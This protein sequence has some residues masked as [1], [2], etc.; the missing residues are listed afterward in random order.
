MNLIRSRA[1]LRAFGLCSAVVDVLDREIELVFVSIV[2][3]AILSS[4]ICEHALQG[5]VVFLVERDDPVDPSTNGANRLSQF[6]NS[7]SVRGPIG[8]KSGPLEFLK[9]QIL[10]MGSAVTHPGSRF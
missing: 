2:G 7:D 10:S 5:N 1:G 9:C 4:A 3:P 8:C 6:N